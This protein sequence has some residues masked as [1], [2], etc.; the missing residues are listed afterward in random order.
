MI[1]WDEAKRLRNI[2]DHGI[3]LAECE[4]I[5]DA[6]IYTEEDARAAYGEKRLESLGLLNG[7]VVVLIWTERATGAHLISCRYGEKY[8]I[9]KYFKNVTY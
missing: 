1:T 6:P 2:K 7:R 9:H 4:S 5:F 8:E 3:D